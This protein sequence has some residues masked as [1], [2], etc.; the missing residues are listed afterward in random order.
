MPPV[1]APITPDML[2][3][4]LIFYEGI[5]EAKGTVPDPFTC[6]IGNHYY[7][8]DLKFY[9]RA[10]VSPFREA[11]DT[12]AQPGEAS[13]N[14]AAAWKRTR[15]DWR[16]GAG[17][18]WADRDQQTDP[19]RFLSS[20]GIDPW[21][22]GEFKLLPDVNVMRASANAVQRVFGAETFVYV[23][24]GNALVRTP[25]VTPASPTFTTITGTGTTI[26][27]VATD[28]YSVFIAN[29]T[30]IFSVQTGGAAA[31]LPG[32]A[33]T[34]PHARVWT[35][36]GWI[37]GS[38]A[39][40]T[41]KLNEIRYSTG[42]LTLVKDHES[43]GFQWA[44]VCGCP[45]AIYAAGNMGNGGW[46]I[47]A[48]TTDNV[49]ALTVP[50][51]AAV[52]DSSRETINIIEC[53]AGVVVIGTNLGVR[54]ATITNEGGLTVGPL[55]PTNRPCFDVYGD[56]NMVWFTWQNYDGSYTGLGRLNLQE[57]TSALVPAYATD[58]M[59]VGQ[60]AVTSVHKD[61]ASGFV[62]FSVASVG[63]VRQ[64]VNKAPTGTIDFGRF[65]WGI[66]EPKVFLGVEASHAPLQGTI[67][68]HVDTDAGGAG[69]DL[70]PDT[71][72]NHSGVGEIHGSDAIM[73]S[74]D[75]FE[76]SVTL[77]RSGTDPTQGPIVYRISFRAL[78][79]PKVVEQ[80]DVGLV[81][82][83]DVNVQAGEGQDVPYDTQ[84]ELDYLK[85]LVRQGLT[86]EYQE[87]RLSSLVTV[88]S[89]GWA[90]QQ[91]DSLTARRDGYQGILLVSM[92]TAE[93]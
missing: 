78:P 9:N 77:T 27:D 88:R 51:I 72:Q 36:N 92:I 39:S 84:A 3:A 66:F 75:W 6:A 90:E 22:L 82:A 48:I 25:D 76:F 52:S 87:L 10:T 35:A 30:G 14:P 50:V 8:Q 7:L 59:Y 49:G 37:L 5:T 38:L 81:L 17:Q 42:A 12:Q 70:D 21:S 74:H 11:R 71:D 56:A 43:P 86:T 40:D 89:V 69:Y 47:Y 1:G 67:A 57:F 16:H 93:T 19:T 2:G 46:Q 4:N 13:L 34:T 60:G 68:Y 73:E 62:M 18:T 53:H 80:I 20:R 32:A 61:N 58:L 79:T 15:D 26:S 85:N 45:N 63:I 29:N 33:G 24:D 64:S 31:A 55:I 23:L 41:S 44:S 28:G 65:R 54:I 91:V 83:Q